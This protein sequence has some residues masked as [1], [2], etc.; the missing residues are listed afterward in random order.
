MRKFARLAG[1]ALGTTALASLCFTPSAANASASIAA[2]RPAARARSAPRPGQVTCVPLRTS[3]GAPVRSSSGR[4]MEQCSVAV[5]LPAAS[6]ARTPASAKADA[7]SRAKLRAHLPRNARDV[8]AA[9]SGGCIYNSDDNPICTYSLNPGPRQ[10]CGG[11]NGDIQWYDDSYGLE[12]IETWGEVWSLCAATAYVYL[13]WQESMGMCGYNEDAGS[14]S[15]YS[16]SGVNY[17]WADQCVAPGGPSSVHETV[18]TTEN[19]W[20]CG[21]SIYV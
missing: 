14:A 17:E 18:C 2:A 4:R 13:S 5:A 6:T 16:T 7:V 10:A 12:Y 8:T 21:P 11:F 1:V 20:S 19:G 15:A 3:T 9:V